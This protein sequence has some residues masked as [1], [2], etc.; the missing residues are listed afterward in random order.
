MTRTTKPTVKASSP[1]GMGLLYGSTIARMQTMSAAVP[2]ICVQK[3]IKTKIQNG[4]L[5]I[6]GRFVKDGNDLVKEA[7]EDSQM[8]CRVRSEDSSCGIF[9]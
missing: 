1:W 7:V 9:S 2:M 5:I 8:I 6:R 3:P 4:T